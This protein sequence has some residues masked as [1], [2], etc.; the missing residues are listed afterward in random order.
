M[1]I[2]IARAARWILPLFIALSCGPFAN[3]EF[4]DPLDT[5]ANLRSTPQQRTLMSVTRAGER[6][7]ALGSRGLVIVSDDLGATWTQSS[8]PVQSDLLAVHFPLPDL[9]WAVG[10]D[11]VVLRSTDGG[12]TWTKQLDG[13]IAQQAFEQYYRDRSPSPARD[14]A[15][16]LLQVNYRAGPALPWLDVWFE[17]S[18]RGFAVGSFGMLM[19]T[20]DGGG[21]WLPWHDRID[22]P[23]SLNLNAVRGIGNDI[24]IVGERG[25]VYRLDR[26]AG[27][28]VASDTGYAGSF[29]GVV[30]SGASV[31]VF[32][33]RGT[34][35]RSLDHGATWNRLEIPGEQT[36]AA[37]AADSERVLLADV[38][39]QLFSA[40]WHDQRAQP[41][42]AE[43]PWHTT[44]IT[45]LGNGDIVLTGLEG[46]AT[47]AHDRLKAGVR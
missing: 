23:D 19:A 17:D 26:E 45:R 14:A 4:R 37:G 30:G 2:A 42:P 35:F 8:V 22:N 31:L 41:H 16:E 10:H 13:R 1:S 29:F 38:A 24:F 25:R 28:F 7:V 18:Q 11:G 43:R 3:A 34:A 47:V 32:G 46:I 39:G 5:P 40:G 6:L 36:L 9:G 15:L 44:G 12:A 20:T 21:H 33:L 27:R